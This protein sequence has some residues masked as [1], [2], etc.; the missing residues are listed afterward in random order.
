VA[1][2]TCDFVD[3]TF[4]MVWGGD[5]SLSFLEVFYRI[6]ASE[7]YSYVGVLN[8]LVILHICGL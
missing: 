1:S 4:V 2:V 5:V 3:D 7:C 6:G 8:R